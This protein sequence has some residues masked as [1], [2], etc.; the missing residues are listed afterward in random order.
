MAITV[1]P[2]FGFA[3]EKHAGGN[4]LLRGLLHWAELVETRKLPAKVLLG[5]GTAFVLRKSPLC[6]RSNID[7]TGSRRFHQGI[8]Q[9][10]TKEKCLTSNPNII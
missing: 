2:L 5:K 6:H 7:V 8:N 3:L 1:G 4:D 10:A 9:W